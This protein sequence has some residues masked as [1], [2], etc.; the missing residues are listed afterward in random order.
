M[1]FTTE[2]RNLLEASDFITKLRLHKT[3]NMD[4]TEFTNWNPC[5]VKGLY[6]GGLRKVSASG[7]TPLLFGQSV[8][9]G[10]AKLL[11][12]HG[13][14]EALEAADQ[15]AVKSNLDGF[16]DPKRNRSVLRDILV[17]YNSHVNIMPAERLVPLELNGT[18]IVEQ[19]FLVPI[20]TVHF[21]AGELFAEECDIQVNWTGVIDAICYRGSEL[22]VVDHKTTSVMG[23]KFIDDKIRSSQ[24]LGYTHVAR[25]LMKELGKPVAGVLIN[26]LAFRSSG[27][28]FVQHPI[29]MAEWKVQEWQTETLLAVSNILK[30]TVDFLIT[31][32][33]APNREA[34]VTKYGQC[35]YFNLCES[36]P[37][38]RDRQLNDESLYVNNAW[39][40]NAQ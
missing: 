18:K 3:V 14:A 19:N 21:K 13:I 30:E 34:C 9:I 6:F 33:V 31:G 10:L 15:D 23:P 22:W 20:G 4:N 27:F 17:G 26:A 36:V 7:A 40:P 37:V 8:H 29:P 11:T 28:E 38:V 39:N 32:E 1:K 16:L 25:L 35:P 24:M 2:F 12:G 5:L